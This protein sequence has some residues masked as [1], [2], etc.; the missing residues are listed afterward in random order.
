M[1]KLFKQ[2]DKEYRKGNASQ[3]FI[4]NLDLEKIKS[5][6]PELQRLIGELTKKEVK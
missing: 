2:F 3:N 5:S 1:T 6:T 4:N